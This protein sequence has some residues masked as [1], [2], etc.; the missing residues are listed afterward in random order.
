MPRLNC[1][2]IQ[3]R[4]GPD[5]GCDLPARL[6]CRAD[7][8]RD[9]HAPIVQRLQRGPERLCSAH[10]ARYEVSQGIEEPDNFIMRIEWDSL[11]GHEKGFRASA[12]FKTFFAKVKPF[13]SSILEMKHYQLEIPAGA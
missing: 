8:T 1:S 5:T 9:A 11:E 6:D 13:F 4:S 12:E 7:F 10:C 3:C 2:A